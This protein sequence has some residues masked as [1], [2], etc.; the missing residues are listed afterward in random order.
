MLTERSNHAK[1]T[2][3]NAMFS[4]DW[5][6]FAE[7]LGALTILVVGVNLVFS[8]CGGLFGIVEFLLASTDNALF[9][10]DLIIALSFTWALLFQPHLIE[11]CLQL[12]NPVP[13]LR[14][15]MRTYSSRL[16]LHTTHLR[17]V[18]QSAHGCRAPPAVSL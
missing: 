9:A 13:A 1:E 7:R 3:R 16:S 15:G 10:A 4:H 2:L 17:S 8:Y 18:P 5:R 6:T 12:F 14:A 11:G